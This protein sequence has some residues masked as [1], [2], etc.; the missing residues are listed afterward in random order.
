[1][2]KI[3][4]LAPKRFPDMPHVP[5]VRVAGAACGLK[6]TRSP[7]L[8]LA[9]LDAGTTVAGVFTRSRCFSAPVAWCR[10]ALS[11]KRVRA[12][13]VNSGNANAFTGLAGDRMGGAYRQGCGKNV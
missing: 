13:V 9:E 10:E 3:S 1:M 6:R 4:P 7:D 2:T 5:G 11:R 12:I 8:F